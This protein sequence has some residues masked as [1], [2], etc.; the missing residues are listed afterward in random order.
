MGKFNEFNE[1]MGNYRWTICA[2]VFFATT[3]NYLDRNVLG[4]LKSTLENEMNWS[5]KDYSH[6]VMAFQLAYALGLLGIGRVIDKVGTKLGYFL[7][8][9]GWSIAAMVHGFAHNTFTFGAARAFLGITEAGNFPAANKTI[10]EWFPKKERAFATGIYNSGANIGSIVAPLCVPWIAINWGWQWAFVITGAIGLLW[11]VFWWTTYKTPFEKLKEGKLKQKEYDFIHSDKDEKQPEQTIVQVT[12]KVNWFKLLTYRQTWSFF[13]GKF[14]TDPIWWFYMFWL[15]AFLEGENMRK[16]AA[17]DVD[18]IISWPF[19]V[20]IV[21]SISTVGSVFGGWLPKYFI[22][23]GKSVYTARM[24]SMFIYALLPLTVLVAQ[25]VGKINTWYAVMLIGL[26]CAGHQAW[27]ANI[28]TTVSDMFPKKAVASVTGIGGMA[29][30]FG[31]MLIAWA[32][33]LLLD[34]FKLLGNIEAGYGIMFIVCALAYITAWIVMKFLV[35]KF[36]VIEDL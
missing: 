29:G 36:R 12:E 32:A 22:G 7:S 8:L 30:A 21:Y 19:A 28:F 3:I 18:G 14:L 6:V 26:A 5:E 15:P 33:G 13:F 17:G 2:L 35:P 11:L 34:H 31:G 1:K 27:S 25:Y 4:L 16:L 9:L 23:K 20:A 24:T 10:A